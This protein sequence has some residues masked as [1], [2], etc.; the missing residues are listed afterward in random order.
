MVRA[1]RQ[2]YIG[3]SDN[4]SLT[5]Q[6]H[7]AFNVNIFVTVRRCSTLRHATHNATTF[8]PV[9]IESQDASQMIAADNT[10]PINGT[11]DLL[12]PSVLLSVTV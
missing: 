2:K 10:I 7:K 9:R 12:L 4:R 3:V 1:T 6:K 8:F 11:L 5:P